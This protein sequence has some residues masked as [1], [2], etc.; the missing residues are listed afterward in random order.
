MTT[1][2]VSK[3]TNYPL[4]KPESISGRSIRKIKIA[5]E[6]AKKAE[7]ALGGNENAF[8]L[9][10][11]ER[12]A[13]YRKDEAL[14]LLANKLGIIEV[15]ITEPQFAGERALV[16]DFLAI[17]RNNYDG[18]VRRFTEG[19]I[20]MARETGIIGPRDRSGRDDFALR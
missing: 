14:R 4:P 13:K 12:M 15:V 17:M 1:F 9:S 19:L 20:E 5:L 2:G 3:I 10:G 16:V 11:P 6:K 8:L 7:E 18:E